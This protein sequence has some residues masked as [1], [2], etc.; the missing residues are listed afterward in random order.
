[1]KNILTILIAL[2]CGGSVSAQTTPPKKTFYYQK[3]AK[4]STKSYDDSPVVEVSIEA[5]KNL[6]F[7]YEWQSAKNPMIADADR[8]DKL[9]FELTPEQAKSFQASGEELAKISTIRCRL[10]FCLDGGCRADTKGILTVKKTSCGKYAVTFKD[11]PDVERVL[12]NET[13]TPKKEK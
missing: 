13:F 10:C 9:Y 4:I 6:V 7:F 11:G 12:V 2:A 3:N 8:T 5:G 1:V